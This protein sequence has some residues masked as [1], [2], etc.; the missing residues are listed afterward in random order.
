MKE[1][2]AFE[3]YSEFDRVYEQECEK[4]KKRLDL[5]SSRIDDLDAIT[6]T[7]FLNEKKSNLELIHLGANLFGDDGLINIVSGLQW[8]RETLKEIYLGKDRVLLTMKS[9]KTKN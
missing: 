9:K 3:M 2:L 7:F 8:H 1:G 4:S 6:I 5:G